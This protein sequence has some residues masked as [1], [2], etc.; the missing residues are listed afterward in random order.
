MR[1]SLAL[2]EEHWMISKKDEHSKKCSSF[3]FVTFHCL[4]LFF[5]LKKFFKIFLVQNMSDLVEDLK[6]GAK[7]S[8][9]SV[10][11]ANRGLEIRQ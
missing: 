3:A 6:R 5:I 11:H 8:S 1:S 2:H 7:T 10:P 9:A 4:G